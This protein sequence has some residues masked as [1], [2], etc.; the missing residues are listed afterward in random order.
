MTGIRR[1]S[2]RHTAVHPVRSRAHVAAV[3]S[4]LLAC[5]THASGYVRAVAGRTL[6]VMTT[7]DAEWLLRMQSE[8]GR[9]QSLLVRFWSRL[10]L[11]PGELGTGKYADM[12]GPADG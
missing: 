4:G 1:R 5:A 6:L 9:G 11:Q 7:P 12:K 10:V 8:R 3:P 2:S